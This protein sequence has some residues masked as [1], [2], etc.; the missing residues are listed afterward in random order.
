MGKR[1]VGPFV[2]PVA[3][4]LGALSLD[5]EQ[6]T[7]RPVEHASET[8]IINFYISNLSALL[9]KFGSGQNKVDKLVLARRA[10]PYLGNPSTKPYSKTYVVD[11]TFSEINGTRKINERST[12]REPKRGR[13]LR[14]Y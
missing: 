7:A 3:W 10:P 12:S 11:N 14:R 4:K 5:S 13:C 2:W 8:D 1:R 9:T 6:N